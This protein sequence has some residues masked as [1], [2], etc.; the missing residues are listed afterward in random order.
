[1]LEIVWFGTFS[2]CSCCKGEAQEALSM[3]LLLLF[4]RLALTH[5][6]TLDGEMSC[7]SLVESISSKNLTAGFKSPTKRGNE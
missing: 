2:N 5:T 3:E 6:P 1:M 4:G 7:D